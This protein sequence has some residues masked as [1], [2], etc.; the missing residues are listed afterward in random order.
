MIA[1]LSGAW[2]LQKLSGITAQAI[3]IAVAVAVAVALV[4]GGI[5]WLRHDARMDERATWET[6][7]AQ[8]EAKAE[9]DARERERAS[10]A[11]GKER[12]DEWA[13]AL[14]ASDAARAEAEAKLA[15]R[16]RVIAYP[17]EIVEAL[18]R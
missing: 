2:W 12:A 16:K 14:A 7:L 4:I 15:T 18:N 11:L 10:E 5:W 9:A 17:K 13:A 8:A 3:G 6:R 1:L